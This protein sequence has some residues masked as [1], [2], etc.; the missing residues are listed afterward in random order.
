MWDDACHDAMKKI[1]DLQNEVE[2][3]NAELRR[4]PTLLQLK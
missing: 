4:T 1:C 2:L 3:C